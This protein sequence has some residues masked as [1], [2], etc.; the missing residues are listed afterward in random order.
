MAPETETIDKS[1]WGPGPWQTEPDR[2]E[3]KHV[4]FA[5]LI[6]RVPSRGALCGYVGVP[7]GHPWHGK[8]YDAVHDLDPDIEVHGGLNY[9]AACYGRVCHV[10][11]PGEPDDLWW[12][13]F[14]HVHGFDL[15]PGH[16][17]QLQKFGISSPSS[18][19]DV[20]RDMAYATTGVEHLAERAAAAKQ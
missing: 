13:G 12:L 6:V 2:K 10:P 20:Y 4:G 19:G 18:L 8:S 1:A 16:T 5:C 17:A 11:E 7:P 15:A 3:W 9:A 14:A